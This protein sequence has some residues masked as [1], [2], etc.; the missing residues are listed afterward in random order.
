[1]ETPPLDG[2]TSHGA[3]SCL[4]W[5]PEANTHTHPVLS[6]VGV[7]PG[8]WQQGDDVDDGNDNDADGGDSTNVYY[9]CALCWKFY[10]SP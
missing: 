3:G 7:G 6:V 5:S 1:M 10:V 4:N 9:V 2:G 8:S